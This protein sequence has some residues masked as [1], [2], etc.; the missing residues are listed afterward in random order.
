MLEGYYYSEIDRWDNA[1]VHIG[2]A[3]ELYPESDNITYSYAVALYKNGNIEEASEMVYEAS[4]GPKPLLSLDDIRFLFYDD[5]EKGIEF[6]LGKLADDP[7]EP[8]L[9][10]NLAILAYLAGDNNLAEAIFT[11]KVAILA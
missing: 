6:L 11:L 9:L 3:Y 7:D 2:K 8:H 4:Q 1:L 5:P 10:F